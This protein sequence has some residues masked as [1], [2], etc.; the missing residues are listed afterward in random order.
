MS[1]HIL[2]ATWDQVDHAALH[3]VQYIHLSEIYD[4]EI[5]S[6]VIVADETGNGILAVLSVTTDTLFILED[7]DG[8]RCIMTAAPREEGDSAAFSVPDGEKVITY[9]IQ[10]NGGPVSVSENR[11]SFTVHVTGSNGS[12]VADATSQDIY[13]AVQSGANVV[14]MNEIYIRLA[15]ESSNPRQAVF[16]VIVYTGTDFAVLIYNID[17]GNVT[18]TQTSISGS[19]SYPPDGGVKETELSSDLSDKINGK[20][21]AGGYTGHEGEFLQ[22]NPISGNVVPSPL[23]VQYGHYDLSTINTAAKAA[24]ALSSLNSDKFLGRPIVVDDGYRN[25]TIVSI[26]PTQ[27]VFHAYDSA[28]GKTIVYTLTSSAIDISYI[29]TR[30]DFPASTDTEVP[31]GGFEP[32]NM[33]AGVEITTGENWRQA[34]HSGSAENWWRTNKIAV[35]PGYQYRFVNFPIYMYQ[36]DSGGG[37]GVTG[38]LDGNDT[39]YTIPNGVYYIGFYQQLPVKTG[40]Q[41]F[42]LTP[43]PEEEA[44]TEESLKSD[45]LS[46]MVS[47]IKRDSTKKLLCP[48]KG[49]TIVNLG[50]S[51]IGKFSTPEDVSS[52]LAE[53]TGAT[54]Y[55]CGFGGSKM[56][57]HSNVNYALFS[58]HTLVDAIVYG[59]FS[60]QAAALE[61][62]WEAPAEYAARLETLEGIDFSKVDIVT[63]SYG[64]ND[65]MSAVALD[66]AQNPK[67]VT[68]YLGSFRYSVEKLLTA[69]PK[70]R[71]I[72]TTP[73]YRTHLADETHAYIENS[74][75]W[76]NAGGK[77]LTDFCDALMAASADY[78]FVCVDNYWQ[79]GF[80]EL[81]RTLYYRPN[82]G[83]HPSAAGRQVIAQNIANGILSSGAMGY[84]GNAKGYLTLADLPIYNGGVS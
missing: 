55:N 84:G 34:G 35:V 48:L 29:D 10:A 62:A 11:S 14:L 20:L 65:W 4:P 17:D 61:S 60:D 57:A 51:I 66:N 49:K 28:N 63:I 24:T 5:D 30:S 3:P 54:V 50:D 74:D 41:M 15:L 39:V 80:N 52:Y 9:T 38:T 68:T 19:G 58:L 81:T 8:R 69:Y 21:D 27:A 71:I 78:K 56:A 45:A 44:A 59:D 18:R 7:L 43:T 6:S 47:N 32:V 25:A 13:E 75:T 33:S 2:T 16:S 79:T 23:P 22:V 1:D 31:G 76:V 77:T 72:P 12:Y 46:L 26:A 36:Y 64:T 42:R 82:D 67:D 83:T 73:I 53:F 70:L 40:I 37:S